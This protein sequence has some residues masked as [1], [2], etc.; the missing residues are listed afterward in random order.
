MTLW[1]LVTETST[2]LSFSSEPPGGKRLDGMSFEWTLI[3]NPPIGKL[4]QRLSQLST[5]Y[6]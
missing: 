6:L 1:S 2:C 4:R 3:K 5:V